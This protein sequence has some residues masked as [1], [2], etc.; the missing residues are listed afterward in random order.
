MPSLI[1][2]TKRAGICLLIAVA[3]LLTVKVIRRTFFPKTPSAP[4]IFSARLGKKISL[5]D[6]DWTKSERTLVLVLDK[7]CKFCLKSAPFYQR[8]IR[9]SA[10]HKEV[11]MIAVFPHDAGEG[12]EYL[13]LIG[14]DI[15][16]VRHAPLESI[17]I[18]GTPTLLLVDKHGVLNGLWMG[19]LPQNSE[20]VVF[21]RFLNG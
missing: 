4:E 5:A 1:N 11:H 13:K 9:E 14:V 16:D 17:G 21:K 15:T 8:L 6:V 20:S 10:E 18:R 3:V 12:K 7:G 19:Q 2:L